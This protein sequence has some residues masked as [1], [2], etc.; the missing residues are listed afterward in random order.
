MAGHKGMVGSAI[1]RKLQSDGFHNLLLRTRQE[2]DLLD[3]HAVERFYDEARPEYVFIAAARVGGIHANNSSRAQFIYENLQIQNNLIHYAYKSKVKKLIF[4]GSSCIYPRDCRQPMKEEYLLSGSLEPTNEPYAVAKIAGI[5]M[6]ENYF[7]QYGCQF[8][9]LMP[10]NS[11]GPND[12]YDLETSHVLPAFIRKLHDAKANNAPEVTLWGTGKPLREFIYVD[13]IADAAL[14]VMERDFGEIYASGI[15]HL[16][17]GTGEEISIR[18]LA[19]LISRI[20]GFSGQLVFDESVP[21]GMPRKLMDNSRLK[22]L[23]WQ[24]NV[25]IEHGV[26]MVYE[27]YLHTA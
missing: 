5:K 12:N 4:L 6:C 14:F 17:V 19:E 13:D 23:G 10:T 25:L 18:R 3:Q 9:S 15:S 22:K 2:I 1:L 26:E 21:D 7:R 8:F 27:T 16:N 11:Y 20:V 24:P